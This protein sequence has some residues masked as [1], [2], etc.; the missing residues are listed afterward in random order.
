M[1][2]RPLPGFGYTGSIRAQSARHGSTRSISARKCARRV[3]FV[4]LSKPVPAS[5]GCERFFIGTSRSH[6]MW[7]V[8]SQHNTPETGR[9]NQRFP[10][11]KSPECD[12]GQ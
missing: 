10:N 6:V 7:L 8:A 3:V 12:Y 1:A 2:G 9:L 11:P 5:V 4:Y